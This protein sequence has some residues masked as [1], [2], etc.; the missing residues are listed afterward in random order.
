[1]YQYTASDTRYNMVRR[2]ARAKRGEC[3]GG[4]R[5]SECD[6][7][8]SRWTKGALRGATA[9]N[10]CRQREGERVSESV[11]VSERERK[12]AREVSE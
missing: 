10:R 12:R 1:M 4:E 7:G 2:I 9:V 3:R 8:E 11:R 6:G 5:V